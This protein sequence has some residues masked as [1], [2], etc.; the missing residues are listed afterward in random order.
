MND[1][2]VQPP[3]PPH[4]FNLSTWALEHQALV[5]LI[6]I[7]VSLSG[8]LS[9]RRLAQSEDP[10]FTFKVMV[11]RTFWPGA[12]ARQVQEELTDRIAR[13]LQA[14]PHVDFLNSYSRP[15][16]S[17]L[18]FTIQDSAPAAQV[19]E[20]WYQVRKRVGRHRLHA[21]GR[22]A[23]TVLQRRVRRRLHQHLRPRRATASRPRS[24]TTG[25]SGCARS[26]SASR[27][28]TRSISSPIR[29]SAST[30]RSPMPRSRSWR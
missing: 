21:A 20:T 13:T 23:G 17:T 2:T 24:C 19:P 15:G 10:P 8:I 14:T 29:S 7:L 28:S 6:L 1:S 4:R 3:D 12:T 25:A 5:V 26:C 11:I 22:R 18:F 30:S 16:E 27:R 9:Y